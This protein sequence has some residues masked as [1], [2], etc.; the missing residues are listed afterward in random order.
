M[1]FNTDKCEIIHITNK[2]RLSGSDYFIRN[3]K[4]TVRTEAKYLGVTIS[5]DLSWS[6]HADNITKKANSTK[7]FLMRNFRSAP[8]AT[9]KTV[10]K[11]SVRPIVVCATTS[12]A[13]FTESDKHKIEM[14]QRRAARF[15]TN[16]YRRT[17][18][19]TEP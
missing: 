7:G 17:S 6:M 2:K 3:K 9:K 10:Y 15:V 8:K 19:A 1:A 16:D 12:W 14:V 4:L 18:S 11:T 13:P 5:S